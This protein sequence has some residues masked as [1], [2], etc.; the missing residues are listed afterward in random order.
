MPTYL[1][2]QRDHF[3][4]NPARTYS[5]HSLEL[6][7]QQPCE[8]NKKIQMFSQQ[9]CPKDVEIFYLSQNLSKVPS[10]SLMIETKNGVSCAFL[11]PETKK[12]K[13]LEMIPVKHDCFISIDFH[14]SPQ[15]GYF[16][17]LPL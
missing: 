6:T 15:N 11:Y 9:H 12:V 17:C 1:F 7:R 5:S 14:L 16:L 2:L 8:G 10:Y 4:C 3:E 13:V